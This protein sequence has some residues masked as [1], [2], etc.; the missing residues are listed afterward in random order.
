MKNQTNRRGCVVALCISKQKHV[1]KTQVSSVYLKKNFGLEH[2]AHAG[3]THRQV[4]FL[5]D[6]SILR[7]KKDGAIVSYGSFGENIVVKGFAW[8]ELKVGD[9]LKI[10]AAA[11]VEVTQLGKECHAPCA[12]SQQ[13]GYCIMPVEGVFARVI[14]S[15]VVKTMDPIARI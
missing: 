9:H 13:A 1:A 7:M 11:V 5:S 15:G 2:D 8:E 14:T 10:G 4:S 6:E 3:A 12:I